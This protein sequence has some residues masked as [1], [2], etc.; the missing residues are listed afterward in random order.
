MYVLMTEQTLKYMYNINIFFVLILQL[1]FSF[2]F[3]FI[4]YTLEQN[5]KFAFWHNFSMLYCIYLQPTKF[6]CLLSGYVKCIISNA[7]MDVRMY[8]QFVILTKLLWKL[9][10]VSRKEIF[11]TTEKDSFFFFCNLQRNIKMIEKLTTIMSCCC[12]KL[13]HVNLLVEFLIIFSYSYVCMF[14]CYNAV[15]CKKVKIMNLD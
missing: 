9:K 2:F 13:L 15:I 10:C 1:V 3:F 6:L 14:E 4:M 12:Q 11:L 8:M 5:F 7:Y